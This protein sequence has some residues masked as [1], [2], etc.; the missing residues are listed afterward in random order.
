MNGPRFY[1]MAV[2]LVLMVHLAWILWVIFGALL[3]SGRRWLTAFH[4]ASLVWGIAVEV[5]PWPCP[6]TIAE[7]FFQGRAGVV[8]NHA[9]FLQQCISSLVYPNISEMLLTICG[10]AVCA[11]NLAIYA[12]RASRCIRRRSKPRRNGR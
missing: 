7:D 11:V 4:I 5:G 8:P 9:S 12:W 1:Q 10:V 6:L 3:T 2:L